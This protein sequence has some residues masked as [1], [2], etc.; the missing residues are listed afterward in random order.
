M[1]SNEKLKVQ[2]TRLKPPHPVPSTTTR[3]SGD[4]DDVAVVVVDEDVV[5]IV[6]SLTVVED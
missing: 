5:S 1:Y 2:R 4:N 3:G 6:A